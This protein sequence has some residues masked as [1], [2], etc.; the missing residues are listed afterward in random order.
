MAKALKS[1]DIDVPRI[2]PKPGGSQPGAG[3]KDGVS[4]TSEAYALYTKAR[5]K[6]TVHEAKLAEMQERERAAQLVETDAVREE[7]QKILASTRAKLL[8][9]PAKLA[10]RAIG[11]DSLAEME[12]LLTEGVHE[13]LQE[14]AN[15]AQ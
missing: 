3:R 6:K 2:S 8:G 11:V 5:A 4:V 14:M 7:W 13:A 12:A 9:L 10:A 15:D 1:K